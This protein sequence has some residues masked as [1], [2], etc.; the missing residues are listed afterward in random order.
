MVSSRSPAF[1]FP[2]SFPFLGYERI[3]EKLNALGAYCFAYFTLILWFGG[4]L[5]VAALVF[6]N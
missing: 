5:N 2:L 3:F 6:V 4:L 1:N